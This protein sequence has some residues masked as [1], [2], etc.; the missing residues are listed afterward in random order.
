MK[1]VS[2]QVKKVKYQVWDQTLKVTW[3]QGCDPVLHQA[4]S[5]VARQK[6]WD[7]VDVQVGDQVRN[8]IWW[9]VRRTFM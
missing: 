4:W 9:Q 8:Q 2:D 7:Q 1:R 5:T 6:A 3:G